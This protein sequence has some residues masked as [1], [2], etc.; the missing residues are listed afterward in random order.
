[1]GH[2]NGPDSSSAFKPRSFFS[3]A[4]RRRWQWLFPFFISLLPVLL[5]FHEARLVQVDLDQEDRERWEKR[6]EVWGA[7]CKEYSEP[8]Y[9]TR[10][11]MRRLVILLARDSG[12]A[13]FG[14]LP[15]LTPGGQERGAALKTATAAR[16]LIEMAD[17]PGVPRG[18]FWAL[19]KEPGKKGR[20]VEKPGFET[21]SRFL[22]SSLLEDMLAGE[23]DP[24]ARE[25][26]RFRNV[27]E[28]R[29]RAL[30]GFSVSPPLFAPAF[31]GQPFFVIFQGGYYQARWETFAGAGNKRGALLGLFPV[32]PGF[33]A[34]P[35]RAMW[36]NWSGKQ[37]FPAFL[38]FPTSPGGAGIR[39]Y[40]PR[41]K[42]T[43]EIRQ[44]LG[45]IQSR[46][47][48]RPRRP[49]EARDHGE[50]A[51]PYD[52]AGRLQQSGDTRYLI[53][54]LGVYAEHLAVLFPARRAPPEHPIRRLAVFG[55]WLW[56]GFWGLVALRALLFRG[57]APPGV[58][59]ELLMWLL[60]VL[61]IP[62]ALGASSGI[63]FFRAY[64]SNLIGDRAA[65]LEK[66]LVSIDS[67]SGLLGKKQAAICRQV[68]HEPAVVEGFCESQWRRSSPQKVID[69]IVAS[70]KSRGL[71]IKGVR[72]YGHVGYTAPWFH[73]QVPL[74]ERSVLA[75]FLD[76]IWGEKIASFPLPDPNLLSVA[77]PIKSSSNVIMRTVAL[78][79]AQKASFDIPEGI[80][81]GKKF[82][83]EL[84][85]RLVRNNQVWFVLG[86]YWDNIQV[87]Q[88]YLEQAFVARR[89]VVPTIDF[90]A[91]HFSGARTR[92]IAVSPRSLPRHWSVEPGQGRRRRIFE[93]HGETHLEVV[94]PGQKLRGYVLSA[95][96][97][98]T[99]LLEQ[100]Q[101]ER[102]Q[103]LGW[104]GLT[105][106]LV[107]SLGLCLT[108]WLAMPIVHMTA[109]L[110]RIGRGDLE[111]DLPG[112]RADELGEARQVLNLMLQ[113]LRERRGMSRFVSSKVMQMIAAG[114]HQGMGEGRLQEVVVL[115]SD[116]RDF[117]TLTETRPP[118]ELF[119]LLNEHLRDMTLA[120]E[121]CGGV[122]DRFI[123][124][125]VVAVFYPG[126]APERRAFGAACQM[127]RA[128][129][130]LVR[131][132]MES[133][134]F[135][136]FIG[137][138]I[139]T[140]EAVSGVT[141]EEAV[142]L[143]LTVLG[144]VVQQA[145]DYE[146]LSKQGTSS[147]IM[148]A[149]AIRCRN[150][151]FAFRECPVAPGVHE[152]VRE[153]FFPP[154]V[155][156]IEPGSY[157]GGVSNA[158]NVQD[159]MAGRVPEKHPEMK[160]M[161]T[162]SAL[163]QKSLPSPGPANLGSSSSGPANPGSA[164]PAGFGSVSP[165]PAPVG[166]D[167]AIPRS[168]P[169]RWKPAVGI[170]M[171]IISGWALLGSG[172]NMTRNAEMQAIERRQAVQFQSL[173]DRLETQMDPAL[174]M[175]AGL[176][177]LLRRAG[178]PSGR[179]NVIREMKRISR[180]IPDLTWAFVGFA[181]ETP[182]MIS[183]ANISVL[184]Q[185]GLAPPFPLN[186]QDI[187]AMGGLVKFLIA[188]GMVRNSNV[189]IDI[190]RWKDA[191]GMGV[192]GGGKNLFSYLT[193]SVGVWRSVPLENRPRWMFFSPAWEGGVPPLDTDF[194][195]LKKRAGDLLQSQNRL[196][197]KV[198]QKLT[199][200]LFC[201]LPMGQLTIEQALPFWIPAVQKEVPGFVMLREGAGSKK[202]YGG[203]R[204]S[205][206][207]R[208][209]LAGLSPL[210]EGIS[211]SRGF[212]VRLRRSGKHPEFWFVHVGEAE[213]RELAAWGSREIASLAGLA[214]VVAMQFLFAWVCLRA[215]QRIPLQ[216]SLTAGF[217]AVMGPVLLCTAMLVE[218]SALERHENLESAQP[219][220]LREIMASADFSSD[221]LD[222]Q[223][224]A[225][226]RKKS[227]KLLREYGEPV[228]V[229]P[230]SGDQQRL[231]GA[232]ETVFESIV[233]QAL[234]LK[235]LTAILVNQQQHNA[236]GLDS[237]KSRK[238]Q[239]NQI[240]VQIFRE[241]TQR[242]SRGEA[243]AAT[244]RKQES[245]NLLLSYELDEFSKGFQGIF[246]EGQFTRAIL[247]PTF[248]GKWLIGDTGQ[249]FFF[250][251]DLWRNKQLQAQV[252]AAWVFPGAEASLFA[253]WARSSRSSRLPATTFRVIKK[254]RPYLVLRE[255][256]GGARLAWNQDPTYLNIP[257]QFLEPPFDDL[258]LTTRESREPIFMEDGSGDQ[259]RLLCVYPSNAQPEY[260]FVGERQIG[261]ILR[262][263]EQAATTRR[264]ILLALI[265]V[266]M[267][268]ARQAARRFLAPL[269]NLAVAARQVAGGDLRV[270]VEEEGN[271]EFRL[272]M[273]SFNHMAQAAEEGR[274]LGSFVSNS[275]KALVREK[276][277]EHVA[278]EGEM[279][280]ACTMFIGLA[281]FTQFRQSVP[282]QTVIF[283]L[284]RFFQA[285][286]NA[287]KAHGG[288][289]DKFIGEK[290]LAVFT[291]RDAENDREAA[292][293][294]LQAALDLQ[295]AAADLEL[296]RRCRLT[297]GLTRGEV[298]AGIMGT[299]QVRLEYTIIGDPVNLASRLCD[300]AGKSGETGSG[301]LVNAAMYD[302]V[303]D[304]AVPGT[305]KSL[306]NVQIKGKKRETEVFALSRFR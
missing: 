124:D 247:A 85:T 27:W 237:D 104:L 52:W 74:A 39:R 290:I 304:Q 190:D 97:S 275:V 203:S 2:A 107:L 9:W 108:E 168:E 53:S 191:R 201:S 193:D 80:F 173:A 218:R 23:A 146:A 172:W 118:A 231:V 175:S 114:D 225:F 227:E 151:E 141:G 249:E 78:D 300:L 204:L 292:A 164:S 45:D 102:R 105:V 212:H 198:H 55:G 131:K 143:D 256:Y 278:V 152:A 177:R 192:F 207:A 161:P 234:R 197:R 46:M 37:V 128:H 64:E 269:A 12:A 15:E 94:M 180:N 153:D 62:F 136:Y 76:F 186:S 20:L 138:G 123:G 250:R 90:A 125:A 40:V 77:I 98:L 246:G 195:P 38:S 41:K 176:R 158:Q 166:W 251:N 43:P 165:G 222:G 60:A 121:A 30:F 16:S 137:I 289:I 171:L 258:S 127:M 236:P 163:D 61:S 51:L 286:A 87:N 306:G 167:P 66:E 120:V 184:G 216:V 276:Q 196:V 116:V 293:R 206:E 18:R 93:Q 230:N 139:A 54:P 257:W 71:E 298:L 89:S 272:L 148:V 3:D 113:K 288:D 183:L 134:L 7:R 79:T 44:I 182:N 75:D 47:V 179:A 11:V 65:T 83:T 154:G 101:R 29:L 70:M 36:L 181:S 215:T 26:E 21:E 157:R 155:P 48:L 260:Q 63:S 99:P 59:M 69:S 129:Q 8:E 34:F 285:M 160:P 17:L 295:T 266:S 220:L 112:V 24:S 4:V 115:V 132:R 217:L 280:Q 284:N 294:A 282:P 187:R 259:R 119:A 208:L 49:G 261:V 100:V 226:M 224:K 178:S 228:P 149:E 255:P 263:T 264:L 239:V 210:Q 13:T 209:A 303:R 271:R 10:R 262:E 82:L 221:L 214:L 291:C 147:R 84:H 283:E 144:D 140:G 109:F 110:Q 135:P 142:R 31:R 169:P 150:N 188:M 86:L 22:F 122:V 200:M 248:F 219:T 254:D 73:P 305:W 194:R 42:A 170:L 265:G 95:R 57:F 19:L 67:G 244:S 213:K 72:V 273:G 274:L 28:A 229:Q 6:A 32:R 111:N 81:L 268:L 205:H 91:F 301:I 159:E 223:L 33:S 117:T 35:L 189:C 202:L 242:F 126:D 299:E 243:P 106:L 241:T 232:L 302:L 296:G 133:G 1:V 25:Q 233:D 245:Q 281:G 240:Y 270:R 267:L 5:L 287:I 88:A 252:H 130:A 235:G 277:L 92:P 156:W 145:G 56:I 96:C 174:Q 211:M 103:L 279:I 297:V 199:G 253:G 162:I 58:N 14:R 238:K 50:I 185:K 68:L